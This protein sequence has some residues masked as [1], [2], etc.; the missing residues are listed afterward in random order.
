MPEVTTLGRT[1]PASGDPTLRVA[2]YIDQGL[3]EVAVLK[4]TSQRRRHRFSESQAVGVQQGY[5]SGARAE[6]RRQA[7][8][9]TMRIVSDPPYA[10]L[11]VSCDQAGPIGEAFLAFV[12]EGRWRDAL[13]ED[14]K[15]GCAGAIF[16]AARALLFPS[17]PPLG[18]R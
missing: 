13:G 12:D 15:T 18:R 6:T 17:E 3:A 11:K 4:E 7:Q 14:M 16:A 8:M 1:V 9:P 10:P 5:E 2:G